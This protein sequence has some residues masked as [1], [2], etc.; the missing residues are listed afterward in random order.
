MRRFYALHGHWHAKRQGKIMNEIRS[1]SEPRMKKALIYARFSTDLQNERSIEDQITL[2]RD[3][4]S[5]ANIDVIDV[6]EDRARS[7][8]SIMGRDGLLRLM[9]RA[10]DGSF[11][12]VVVEALDRLS[13]D[14]EDLAG[15]HKRLSFL[16]IEI[17]AVH[18][19]VV[20]TVLVGLRGLVGQLYREDN[21][22]KVR[23]GLSGRVGQGLNAGGRAYGYA[24]IAGDKGKR[25]IVEA[26]AQIVRRIF[27]EYIGGRT[28]REIAHDLNNEGIAPPRG[29]SWNASTINGNMQRGTGLIQNELYA[30]RLVWNKVR[31][32]KD[33]DTGKRLSRPNAKKDWQT[34]DVPE[35]RIVSQELFNAAQSRKQA[36]G[37]T[38]PNKQRRPRHMLSGMLRCGA[39][40]AGMSTNGKDKSE[41]IR[42]RCS[43][44]TESGTCRDAK[45]FYLHTV[46]SAVLA[47]L[48]AE[49]Q[50]PSVIAEYVRTYLEE[51]KRL[52][53]KANAKRAHL[54][55]RLGELNREIDRLVDAIAKGQGDP[56][57]LG[58]RS[59][60]LNE[61]RKQIATELK[62]EPATKET[63]ALHPAILASYERQLATLQ[64]ALSK[65][66]N[67]GDSDAAEAIRDLV[68]TVTVFRDP[69]R[70]GGVVVEIAG[71]LNALLGENAYPNKVRGVWGKVVAG[72][73]LEPPTPGL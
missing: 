73:G 1:A 49:M 60:V 2:C 15:I 17:R 23:R 56:A 47:G 52:S 71:R 33:P 62:V 13:R 11:D 65:G 42:I 31:M 51:R 20:N 59:T 32:V 41:R 66:I 4:A 44:A 24:P 38:H 67:A 54:E 61:E 12:I 64:D 53:A 28:P 22:H 27:E 34:A 16:G 25:T 3:Y 46:E 6:Y 19:G 37:H 5:R 69:A 21:A 43:A 26:E 29:R 36:R 40:G 10:K 72:E 45:T 39:C 50:H 48:E 55:T 35:L 57:V 8:G 9:D 14:M 7:G 63:L 58:P 70:P 30:G 68:E 18:E